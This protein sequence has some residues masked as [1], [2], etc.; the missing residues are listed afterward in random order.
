[1]TRPGT[2]R[3]PPRR[4]ARSR[5]GAGVRLATS[6]ALVAGAAAVAGLGTYGSFTSSTSASESLAAGEVKLDLT[7]QAAQGFNVAATGLVPGDSAQR[8]VQLTRS[9]ATEAFGSVL[10]STTGAGP[11]VTDAQGLKIA[12]DQC[13]V[14]WTK[15]N[16]TMVLSCSGTTTTVLTT[17]PVVMTGQALAPVTTSLNGTGA[18]ANLRVTLS[19]PTEAGNNLQGAAATIGF[20]FDA[21]QRAAQAR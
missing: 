14:P 8:A 13:T 11:L 17:R 19:L 12:V 10:L 2:H 21:T 16:N 15:V 6:L 3:R 20:T 9:A 5:S 1:M 18:A 7:N 4:A